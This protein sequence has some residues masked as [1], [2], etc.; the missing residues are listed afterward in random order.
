MSTPLQ[1]NL[2]GISAETETGCVRKQNEQYVALRNM[3]ML[4]IVRLTVERSCHP[5]YPDGIAILA[6]LAKSHREIAFFYTRFNY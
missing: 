5:S 3:D 1:N 2:L 4:A 6:L